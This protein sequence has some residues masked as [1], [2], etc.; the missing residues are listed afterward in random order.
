MP[1][2]FLVLS[3]DGSH[4]AVPSLIALTKKMCQFVVPTLKT[5]L[6]HFEP[7]ESRLRWSLTAN[8]WKSRSAADQFLR[9][10]LLKTIATHMLRPEGFVIFHFDGDTPYRERTASPNLEQFSR[11]IV[12]PVSQ[13]LRQKRTDQEAA[14]IAQKLIVYIPH[15]CVEAWTYYNLPVLEETC[16]ARVG[17]RDDSI[18]AAWKATPS[19]IEEVE[20]PWSMVSAGKDHNRA[21]AERAYPAAVA[22]DAG[23]SFSDTVVSLQNNQQLVA[24]LQE[25][26]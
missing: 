23:K 3:E 2:I 9:T 8:K 14:R 17:A 15:Y 4:D 7:P 16:R 13:L 18:L 22:F 1:P 11:Q 24:V 21:L 6:L 5:H 26:A 19:E 25:L 12:E 20:Q 10:D